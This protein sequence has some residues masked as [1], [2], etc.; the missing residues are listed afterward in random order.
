MKPWLRY[1]LVGIAGAVVGAAGA[2]GF[3]W[4]W[5][6]TTWVPVSDTFTVIQASVWAS[7]ARDSTDSAAYED[8][9]RAYLSVLDTATLRD[10]SGVNQRMYRWD[11]ALTLIR[12]SK[13]VSERGTGDAAAQLRAQAVALCPVY[14]LSPCNADTLADLAQKLERSD[15]V[16]GK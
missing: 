12:L 11:K 13:V 9:L 3:L 10:S 1:T 5:A 7:A 2:I 8:A 15:A 6:V 16:G 14:G 4:R